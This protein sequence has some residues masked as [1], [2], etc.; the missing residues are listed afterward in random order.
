[1]SQF[2]QSC[3]KIFFFCNFL[4]VEN[5][6]P[7]WKNFHFA[8]LGS[9]V[10]NAKVKNPKT[11]FHQSGNFLTKSGKF[12]TSAECS[13]SCDF[14]LKIFF[15]KWKIFQWSGKNST[16]SIWD[17]VSRTC[18]SGRAKNLSARVENFAPKVVRHPALVLHVLCFRLIFLL[19][20][21]T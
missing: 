11:K 17:E 15:G 19:K 8:Y 6:P 1:M 21:N 12:S 13:N 14:G 18:M 2:L 3:K 4:K 5:F 16:I 10:A 20:R 7:K 9:K